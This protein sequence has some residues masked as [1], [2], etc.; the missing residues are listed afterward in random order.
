MI[1]FSIVI[2][3]YNAEQ[4][5]DRCIQSI[6]LQDY[7]FFELVLIDDGSTDRSIDILNRYL[8][9]DKRIKVIRQNNS[10]VGI[11]RN[12]GI[13]NCVGSHLL[14]VDADDTLAPSCLSNL[15]NIIEKYDPDMTIFNRDIV[16][17]SESYNHFYPVGTVFYFDINQRWVNSFFEGNLETF[18]TNKCYKLDFLKRYELRFLSFPIFEDYLFIQDCFFN[19]PK[20]F[21]LDKKMYFYYTHQGSALTKIHPRMIDAITQI[22]ERNLLLANENQEKIVLSKLTLFGFF[23][24]ILLIERKAK[25]FKR[26][27]KYKTYR[28]CSVLKIYYEHQIKMRNSYKIIFFFL[29][30][31]LYVLLDLY[32]LVFK[33]WNSFLKKRRKI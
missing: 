4:Y 7:A 15:K 8:S 31:G 21:F 28:C 29:S 10:G 27:E 1:R 24:G 20:M 19:N 22:Y 13:D 18:V 25:F 33:Y 12:I 17:S 23:V 3:I 9:Y 16:N 5:L 11:A 2:P 26:L 32:L 14:F 30:H 6:L